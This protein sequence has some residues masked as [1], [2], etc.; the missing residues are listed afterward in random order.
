MIRNNPLTSA[1]LNR[2]PATIAIIATGVQIVPQLRLS[3]GSRCR[4][5][6][7]YCLTS[8]LS[9]K[10][11]TTSAMEKIPLLIH[12]CAA[13]LLV[14]KNDDLTVRHNEFILFFGTAAHDRLSE[15]TECEL[16][17]FGSKGFEGL[18]AGIVWAGTIIVVI[19]GDVTRRFGRPM[20]Q[21]ERAETA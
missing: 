10:N 3:K 6:L 21:Q 1:A 20:F 13:D 4:I 11:S 5:R 17:H 14:L 16:F 15:R 2:P 7:I 9:V 12:P 18:K 8:T 19:L